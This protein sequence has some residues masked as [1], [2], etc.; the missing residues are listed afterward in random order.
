M[1]PTTAAGLFGEITVSAFTLWQV[2]LLLGLT[3][4][5]AIWAGH[6]L[7]RRRRTRLLAEGMGVEPFLSDATLGAFMALLGLLLAFTFGNALTVAQSIKGSITDE[8][9]VI[10]TAFLR[11]DYL[12]EPV[13]TELQVALLDYGRSRV[14][15]KGTSTTKIADVHAF[16]DR[17]LQAQ[18][19]LWPLT[20]K[21]TQDPFPAPLKGFVAGAV[22][23]VLDAHLYRMATLS[24]PLASFMQ[25]VV[26]LSIMVSLFLLGN[27]VGMVGNPMTWRLFSLALFMATTMYCVID[28]RRGNEGLLRVDDAPLRATIF[29]ME[30]ALKG[31][32]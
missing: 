15:P 1:E 29:D 20:L 21:G 6:A 18:A 7:G 8:A 24:V 11:A 13:R 12:E 17:S 32:I 22:N 30:Q 19:K 2:L 23:D 14:V 5:L 10:G 28:I 27:N 3:P 4:P 16:V 9:A 25:L 26:Y 31:R